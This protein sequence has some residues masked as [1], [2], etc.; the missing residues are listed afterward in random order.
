MD[1]NDKVYMQKVVKSLEPIFDV[2]KTMAPTQEVSIVFT[3][4]QEPG[5]ILF[6]TVEDEEYKK[7]SSYLA[8]KLTESSPSEVTS[9]YHDK[10]GT[11]FFNEAT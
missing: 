10:N 5:C 4:P 7:S 6:T 2:L 8:K 1:A 9:G 11:V 3:H